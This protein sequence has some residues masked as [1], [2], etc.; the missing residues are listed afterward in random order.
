MLFGLLVDSL[1][2]GFFPRLSS[3]TAH[4]TPLSFDRFML[5]LSIYYSGIIL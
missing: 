5:A 2:C 4:A 1:G 3:G